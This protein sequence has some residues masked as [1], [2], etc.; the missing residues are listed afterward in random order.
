MNGHFKD[1]ILATLS[2]YA[3]IAQFASY[4]PDFKPRHS[5]VAGYPLDYVFP[6][7]EEATRVILGK[8][9]ENMVNIRS[10]DPFNPK[11]WPLIRA[12]RTVEETMRHARELTSQG[13]YIIIH[14][15]IIDTGR[16]SGVLLGDV[17][18][19]APNTTPRCVEP[20]EIAQHG[21][22]ASLS[23]QA[24][25][26]MLEK[27]YGHKPALDYPPNIRVEFSVL[28]KPYGQRQQNTLVWETENMIDAAPTPLWNW[29]N[30]FSRYIG[31]KTFGLVLA[32]SLGARVPHTQ[33]IGRNACFT[34]GTPTGTIVKWTRTAP[35]E[36]QPGKFIT[37]RG[38]TDPFAI[39][40]EDHGAIA[41]VLIQ[42][43]VPFAYSGAAVNNNGLNI[44][45]VKGAGD[46]FMLGKKKPE[47]LP[48]EVLD[49]VNKTYEQLSK[50]LGPVRFEWVYDGTNIWVVQLH[51]GTVTSTN[52][53]IVPGT[54]S[55]FERFAIDSNNIEAFRQKVED[56]KK[57]NYGLEV[58]GQFGITSHIGDILRKAQ[59]PSRRA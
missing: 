13:L 11:G 31:D 10:F 14:E 34:F 6:S 28:S 2:R 5:C 50:Q 36:Q 43:E 22:P 25:F 46:E 47:T 42:Q 48:L 49:K 23:R 32:D 30:R 1:Q 19:F 33:V 40:K 57:N 39:M 9:Q 17:I 59:V 7:I 45:G 44:E 56:A 16:T 4:G 27:V 8:A 52:E 55:H 20:K 58:A 15:E 38:Y 21:I 54:P 41:A 53:V 24:G 37:T 29:P 18:E 3:N 51:R 26:A 35:T 12:L